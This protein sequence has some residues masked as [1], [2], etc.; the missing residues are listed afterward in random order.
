MRADMTVRRLV[1]WL[2]MV[3]LVAAAAVAQEP[4]SQAE[5]AD[6]GPPATD[7]KKPER[8]VNVLKGTV[9]DEKTRE[10]LAGVIVAV[11]DVEIGHISWFEE[12]HVYVSASE[13]KVL[14]FFTKHNG[15][16][17]GHVTT[18]DEGKFAIRSLKHG[19]YNIAAI[20]PDKG[21]TL[22]GG[23]SF[24]EEST[25]LEIVLKPFEAAPA[26][27]I[28]GRV[29]DADGKP[30]SEA[31][32]NV[33]D[34]K[35][36]FIMWSGDDNVFAYAGDEA[37][38]EFPWFSNQRR[39]G[40]VDGV[41]TDANG[42]FSIPTRKHG[43]YTLLAAHKDKGVTVMDG[44]TF[45]AN[46]TPLE[47][48][49]EAPAF[50]EGRLKGMKLKKTLFGGSMLQLQPEG[51]PDRVYLDI[52]VDYKSDG[53]FRAGPV[54][55]A[56]KWTLVA[57]RNVP[58]Q[59]YHA[60]LL[61]APVRLEPGKTVTMDVDLTENM[62]FAGEVRGPKDEPLSGVSVL[63]TAS[64][65]SGWAFGAVTGNDGKYTIKGLPEG[66]YTLEAMRHVKRTAPG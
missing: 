65:E 62:Q 35:N 57:D 27:V 44:V 31:S 38:E 24:S 46:S 21:L 32:V 45:G 36:G 55:K 30:I 19:T 20:H 59:G 7:A 6:G 5:P 60:T 56:K 49:I 34:T 18:D 25:P 42:E 39:F 29:L 13:E 47:V 12:R 50:V 4:V 28:K 51:L 41:R 23:I 1:A 43:S 14:L 61:R 54:P 26:Q 15:K 33:A 40:D 66:K 16:R 8:S 2:I 10:P 37:D 22:E 9:L 63:V 3:G 53:R 11:A 52:D 17:G 48:V 58:K 64:D